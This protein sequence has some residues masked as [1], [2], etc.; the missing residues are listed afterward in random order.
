MYTGLIHLI[1]GWPCLRRPSD[2]DTSIE[3]EEMLNTLAKEV[4]QPMADWLAV[5]DVSF[6]PNLTKVWAATEDVYMG[7]SIES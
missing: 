4:Q 5:R 3:S 1:S 6:D 2:S 7:T